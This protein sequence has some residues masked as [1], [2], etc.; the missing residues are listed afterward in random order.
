MPQRL[1][2]MRSTQ[3]R[4]I[5]SKMRQVPQAHA[6]YLRNQL[7]QRA[8]AFGPFGASLNDGDRP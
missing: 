3:A 1:S 7:M 2:Q 4:D 8:P 6:S 5:N